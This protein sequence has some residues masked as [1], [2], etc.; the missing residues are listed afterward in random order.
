MMNNKVKRFIGKAFPFLLLCIGAFIMLFPF[1]WSVS[2]SLQGPG[3]AYQWPPEFFK[4]PFH[5]ENF[6]IAFVEAN[7]LRYSL[8]SLF[9]TILS[10]IGA[11]IADSLAGYALAKY[12]SRAMTIVFIIALGTMYVP[13]NIL[14]VPQYVMWQKLG[15]LN[16][17]IPIILPK[18]FGDIAGIFLMRQCFKSMSNQL[19]EAAVIDGLHPLLIFPRIYLPLA[20]P[21]IAT[22]VVRAFMGEW[23]DL[24]GPLIYLNDESKYT[25]TVGLR[26]LIEK[27]PQNI[28]LL[29]ASSVMC[30][31]PVI[32]VYLCAQKYFVEGMI[33]SGIKG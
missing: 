17:Y 13:G 18:F 1:V 16:T 31:I 22:L 27:F 12:E 7:I 15:M 6:K 19:Y 21:M 32:L 3:K 14:A 28:E 30:M 4:P 25:I 10:V 5:F 2:T 29:I 26:Y 9:V 20:K 33:S 23:N 11:V 8:N 24:F